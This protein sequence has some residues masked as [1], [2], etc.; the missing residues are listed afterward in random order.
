MEFA[1]EDMWRKLADQK[2]NFYAEADEEHRALYREWMKSVLAATR[3]TVVFTKADGTDRT[4]VC[5][6]SEAEGAKYS[7]TES[8]N[9]RKPNEDVCVV[10]DC[11]VGGW[12][13]F[14]WDRIKGVKFNIG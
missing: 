4:M 6:L 12:R 10:W 8:T 3:T 14:R 1:K 13:S 5:T 9:K 11:E 7:V 2:G